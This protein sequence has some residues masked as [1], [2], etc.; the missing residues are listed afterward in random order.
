MEPCPAIAELKLGVSASPTRQVGT[1]TGVTSKSRDIELEPGVSMPAGPS[2]LVP[3]LASTATS[4]SAGLV[5][6]VSTLGKIF[7]RFTDVAPSPPKS[8]SLFI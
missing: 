5:H 6:G 4:G 3:S 7:L 8:A 2:E 1:V